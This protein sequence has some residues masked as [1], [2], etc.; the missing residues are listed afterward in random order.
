MLT[1]ASLS[2]LPVPSISWPGPLENMEDEHTGDEAGDQ[3]TQV[4]SK[5]HFDSV[6]FGFLEG[7]VDSTACEDEHPEHYQDPQLIPQGSVSETAQE[8]ACDNS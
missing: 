7:K 1:P 5:Q 8:D 2:S 6:F 3:D 4:K